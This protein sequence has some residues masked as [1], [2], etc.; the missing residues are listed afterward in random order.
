MQQMTCEER[1][2]QHI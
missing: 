2:L 1:N